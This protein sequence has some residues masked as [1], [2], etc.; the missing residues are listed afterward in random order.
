MPVQGIKGTVTK[1]DRRFAGQRKDGTDYSLQKIKLRD[2]TGEITCILD[3]R[4]PANP[5]WLQSQVAITGKHGPKGWSGLKTKDDTY[6]DK[7][8]FVLKVYSGA[9]IDWAPEG[10]AEAQ[11]EDDGGL[12]PE[13]PAAGLT[14]GQRTLLAGLLANGISP[15]VARATV[16]KMQPAGAP[17][18]PQAAPTAPAGGKP[19]PAP[20]GAPTG[21]TAPARA[22]GKHTP[23]HGATVGMCLKEAVSIVNSLGASPLTTIYYKEVHN[24]AS[25]LIRVALS[26]EAGNLAPNLK[27]QA[28]T[29]GGAS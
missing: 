22:N 2:A 19:S 11:E 23:V 20:S 21:A 27:E 18:A 9:E 25:Q 4:E 16:L 10:S 17:K 13:K 6:K 24:I 12:G 1:I 14:P 29:D 15:E 3:G 7:S 26:L 28:D 8:E 5:D